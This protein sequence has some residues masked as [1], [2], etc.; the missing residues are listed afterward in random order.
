MAPEE[1]PRIF[2]RFYRVDRSRSRSSGGSGIGL[3]IVDRIAAAHGWKIL[4]ESEP[5]RGSVFTVE[6]P[7][8]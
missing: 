7:D 8:R 4:A 2:E 6:F 3:A 1:L 5:G